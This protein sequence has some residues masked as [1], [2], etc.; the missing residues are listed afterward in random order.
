[1][2]VLHNGRIAGFRGTYR[3][4]SNFYLASFTFEGIIMPSVEHGYQM[5]KVHSPLEWAA[6]LSLK[7]PADVKRHGKTLK[8]RPDWEN[9][10]LKIMRDIVLANFTQNEDLKSKLLATGEKEL[11]ELN[12]WCDLF[13]GICNCMYMHSWQGQNYMGLTL[14]SVRAELKRSQ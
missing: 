7:N 14:M 8:I 11:I 6:I 3:W 1:M 9:V 2:G 12:T 4:L 5:A 13:W 10:K